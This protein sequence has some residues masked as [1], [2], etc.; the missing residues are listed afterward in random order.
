MSILVDETD[1]LEALLSRMET[2]SLSLQIYMYTYVIYVFLD[3]ANKDRFS[4]LLK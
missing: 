1:P 2:L 4:R 3:D